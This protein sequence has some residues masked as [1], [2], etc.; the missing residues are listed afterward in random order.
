MKKLAVVA[1]IAG[2]VLLSQTDAMAQYK[3]KNAQ[4]AAQKT[5]AQ[6]L[7]DEA[8]T[9]EAPVIISLEQA[10]EIALSENVSVKVADMEIK[11][12]EY[13]KKGS[14]AALY[15]QFDCSGAYQRTIKKQVMYMDID[16]SKLSGMM[17]GAG[18]G[19][20]MPDGSETPG[21]GQT[22]QIP[23]TEGGA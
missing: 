11:R 23:E 17:G 13:A 15:P 19:G 18:A 12:T 9:S 16:M 20:Q 10:L 3:D 14:Y 6:M 22:P 7:L 21:E 8:S 5:E 2:A 4:D 1:M